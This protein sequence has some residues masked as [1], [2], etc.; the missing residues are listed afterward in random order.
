MDVG[1]IRNGIS[2]DDRYSSSHSKTHRTAMGFPFHSSGCVKHA[3]ECWNESR[4]I[5]GSA[6]AAKTKEKPTTGVNRRRT[7]FIVWMMPSPHGL[8]WRLT[9]FERMGEGRGMRM[10]QG[11]G[12]SSLATIA[13]IV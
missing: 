8:L 12:V 1:A 2:S 3:K 13:S 10:L 9:A 5:N 11:N 6:P 4:T 7:A